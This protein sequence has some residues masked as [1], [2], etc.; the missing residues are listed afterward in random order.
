MLSIKT[1][2]SLPTKIRNNKEECQK[3]KCINSWWGLFRKATWLKLLAPYLLFQA[4]NFSY[5]GCTK[6]FYSP[7]GTRNFTYSKRK[8]YFSTVKTLKGY[9]QV[10]DYSG[11]QS[12]ITPLNFWPSWPFNP[13]LLNFKY[14]QVD[15]LWK[16]LIT[17]S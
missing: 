13:P 14:G 16:Y 4:S 10:I 3:F 6:S 8:R 7:K 5:H 9:Q 1:I 15:W 11:V 2:I 12:I 17:T